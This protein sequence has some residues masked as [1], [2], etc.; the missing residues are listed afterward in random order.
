MKG[1]GNGPYMPSGEAVEKVLWCVDCQAA[2]KNTTSAYL[3]HSIATHK[4][5]GWHGI[6]VPADTVPTPEEAS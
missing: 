2:I 4:G 5:A 1:H 6:A 3:K